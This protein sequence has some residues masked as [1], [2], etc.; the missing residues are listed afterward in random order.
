MLEGFLN[1]I[2]QEL[3]YKSLIKEVFKIDLPETLHTT[4]DVKALQLVPH[5]FGDEVT[6]QN[7]AVLVQELRNN[8]ARTLT[9]GLSCCGGT[10]I[11]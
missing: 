5:S 9:E 8:N 4:F 10:L 7:I 1:S 6:T 2:E 11:A 3:G